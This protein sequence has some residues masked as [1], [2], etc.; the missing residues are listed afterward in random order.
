MRR[1]GSATALVVVAILAAC[2]TSP[3]SLPPLTASARNSLGTV[4]VI[5]NGPAVGGKINASVGAGRQAAIGAIEGGG[6]GFASGAG[7]GALLGLTCGPG[8]LACVPIGA[9]IG[10][11]LGL[12]VGIPFGG[13]VKGLNAIPEGAATEIRDSLTRAI[14]DRD[15][16]QDLRQRVLRRASNRGTGVDLGVRGPTPVNPPD[17][18]SFASS[19]IG[20]VLEMSLTQVTFTSAEGGKNPPLSLV[21]TARARLIHIEDK[22]V[23]WDVDRVR[24]QSPDAAFSLWAELDS[25]LLKAEIDNGL[26][27]LSRQIGDA[28]FTGDVTGGPQ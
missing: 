28:L 11:A 16:Q 8:A 26:D 24:Y 21:L 25:T 2:A 20:T 22:R 3:K 6:V 7:A 1:L 4:G 5:T 23:L 13:V 10:G 18:S 14:A 19:G 12:A 15:L 27:G 9:A 17:Y